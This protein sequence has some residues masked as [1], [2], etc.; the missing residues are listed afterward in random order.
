MNDD[1]W[2]YNGE[3]TV[4]APTQKTEEWQK[5]V[6][7]QGITNWDEHLRSQGIDPEVKQN[8]QL[9]LKFN[10]S[11]FEIL[12]SKLLYIDPNIKKD[13]VFQLSR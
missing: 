11:A 6:N 4:A 10:K 3:S 8:H 12:C 1:V 7:S 2:K 13:L 5:H 9:I